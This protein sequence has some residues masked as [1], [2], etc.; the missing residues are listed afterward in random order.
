[1]P[2]ALAHAYS[3]TRS[4]LEIWVRCICTLASQRD[5]LKNASARAGEARIDGH[6][7]AHPLRAGSCVRLRGLSPQSRRQPV[8]PQ[9]MQE[10]PANHRPATL[11]QPPAYL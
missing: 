1:M 9:P 3:D 4:L 11:Q 6:V 10:S 7:G 2:D 8:I 5:G